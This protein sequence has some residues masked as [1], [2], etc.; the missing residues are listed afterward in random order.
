MVCHSCK[1]QHHKDEEDTI[2]CRITE[3]LTVQ[4]LGGCTGIC[5][6]CEHVLGMKIQV[7]LSPVSL[8]TVP[9]AL[10]VVG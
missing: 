3:G 7:N 6:V 4:P 2:P 10:S 9:W 8:G 1:P 5:N